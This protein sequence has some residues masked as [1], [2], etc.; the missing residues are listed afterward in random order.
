MLPLDPLWLAEI[1]LIVLIQ[2]LPGWLEPFMEFVSW[3][4]REEFF[5]I[6]LP[7]LY[8]CVD[9]RLGVRVGLVL[10]LTGGI[11]LILKLAAHAPRPYWYDPDVRMLSTE[12][13]FGLPSGHAQMSTAI[14]GTLAAYRN[15][16]GAWWAASI[17]VAL[18]GFSRIYLGVHFISDVVA[19]LLLGLLTLWAVLRL[20]RPVVAWWQR[21][22]L[23]AQFVLS[24]VIPAG[25]LGVALIITAVHT[26]TV[27]PGAWL[28]MTQAEAESLDKVVGMAGA[29]FGLLAA[30]S[31]MARRDFF[32]AGGSVVKRIA[33]YLLGS[34]GVGIIYFGL[35]LVFPEEE[36]LLAGVLRF[37][38]YALLTLWVLL[39]AP[40]LFARIGLVDRRQQPDTLR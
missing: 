36:S 23:G 22:S 37:A 26:G 29:L 32:S 16:A 1:D 27:L 25:L 24:A 19:G 8:W 33:R 17:L 30:A 2:G 35:K 13:T 40:V 38:R 20:E 11:N 39:G 18:I 9:P 4:G 34:I 7:L 3:L 28:H 10:L 15:R 31:V 5:L 21:F 12:D 14:W 6:L